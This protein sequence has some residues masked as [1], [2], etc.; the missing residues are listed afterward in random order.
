MK[1]I[2]ERFNDIPTQL[3]NRVGFSGCSEFDGED[4]SK[5][6][7]LRVKTKVQPTRAT[8]MA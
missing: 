8:P 2:Q 7:S 3:D 1:R 5:L 6:T 4:L